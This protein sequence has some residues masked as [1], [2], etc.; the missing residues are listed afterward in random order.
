VSA[1][2]ALERAALAL[3]DGSLALG[4][5]HNT[6]EASQP[7]LDSVQNMLGH[8]FP[9]IL[10]TTRQSI[11]SAGASAQAIDQ[12]LRALSS[13]RFLTGVDYRP[14]QSLDQ[15]LEQ[16]AAGLEPLPESLRVVAQDLGSVGDSLEQVNPTILAT[17]EELGLM[18]TSL[19]SSAERL[20]DQLD[21]FAGL[22][23]TLQLAAERAQSVI[24]GMAFL[25]G[26]ALVWIAMGQTAVLYTGILIARAGPGGTPSAEGEG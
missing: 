5:V 22:E 16:V 8:D 26:L 25:A 21:R 2:D 23:D 20:R 9:D 7:F 3:D 11:L 13:I 6:L 17:G 18:S 10:E 1:T 14:E 19:R 4:A 24:N 15:S 12:V